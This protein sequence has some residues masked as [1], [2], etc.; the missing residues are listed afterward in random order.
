[1]DR[2]NEGGNS[3]NDNRDFDR[4]YEENYGGADR[5]GGRRRGGYDRGYG[6]DFDRE[7]Y[8][9]GEYE[10]GSRY[11]QGRSMS[12]DYDRSGGSRRDFDRD[13]DRGYGSSGGR[14]RDFYGGNYG[15]RE[16]EYDRPS[17]VGGRDYDRGREDDQRYGRQERGYSSDYGQG[18]GYGRASRY[19]EGRERDVN[20]HSGYRSD[21]WDREEDRTRSY[22]SGYDRDYDQRG[23]WGRNAGGDR[24]GYGNEGFSNR[25]Y[26]QQEGRGQGWERDYDERDMYD[27]HHQFYGRGSNYGQQ[28]GASYGSGNQGRTFT[29]TEMWLIPGPNVGQGPKNYDPSSKDR[30]TEQVCERLSQHGG[31]DASNIEVKAENGEVTL[32]GSVGS[33]EAKRMAEDVA[34]S[35]SGVKDV[36]NQLR[37]QQQEN[38]NGGRQQN[39]GNQ[40]ATSQ[41]SEAQGKANQTGNSSRA[42]RS[43]A[44]N[45]SGS[46]SNKSSESK[47]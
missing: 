24:G 12:R 18:Y 4:R 43:T 23:G 42:S 41:A 21:N 40:N 10:R 39:S 20:R 44:S 14:D 5:S 38:T 11:G 7:S 36:H 25:G 22:D 32:T 29:Y 28:G 35:V 6:D 2:Y 8:G 13:A 33:R 34:E 27:R 16:S 45:A 9:M 26:G 46:E 47:S 15:G 3:R 30:L 37:V 31:I 17:N 19:G 1:M